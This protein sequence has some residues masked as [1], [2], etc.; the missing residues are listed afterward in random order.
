MEHIKFVNAKQAE[1]M[2]LYKIIK[3]K[4]HNTV[5]VIWFNKMCKTYQLSPKYANIKVKGT[6]IRNRKTLKAATRFKIN[7]ELKFL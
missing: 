7:Q 3:E 1:D 6:D 4:L 2:H 5:A